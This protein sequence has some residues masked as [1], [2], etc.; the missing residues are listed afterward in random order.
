[1]QYFRTSLYPPT[2]CR[3][4]KQNF[5]SR[6]DQSNFFS[7]CLLWYITVLILMNAFSYTLSY[8]A[9]QVLLVSP[10][11]ENETQ[12]ARFSDLGTHSPCS[13]A[14]WSNRTQK[15]WVCSGIRKLNNIVPLS[16]AL[17][18]WRKGPVDVGAGA[19]N[20]GCWLLVWRAQVWRSSVGAAN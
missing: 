17:L 18:G 13:W 9:L 4:K 19:G 5:S 14:C 6:Q 8:L 7:F 15:S 20:A 2:S 10:Q 16:Q 3:K 11:S 1:M 12:G